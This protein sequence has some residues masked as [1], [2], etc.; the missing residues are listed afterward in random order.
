MIP[1]PNSNLATQRLGDQPAITN[2]IEQEQLPDD[3]LYQFV[4]ALGTT[5]QPT[6]YEMEIWK[7]A[8]RSWMRRF[9]ANTVYTHASQG[10]VWCMG[11][12]IVNEANYGS[13]FGPIRARVGNRA[14]AYSDPGNVRQAE[15]EVSTRDAE[16]TILDDL[17]EFI[18]DQDLNQVQSL[19]IFIIG[20]QGPC[21]ICQLRIR[22]F[23]SDLNNIAY[24][25]H[26]HIPLVFEAVYTT[27]YQ[28]QV[29]RQG[30][31]TQYGYAN[32]RAITVRPTAGGAPYSIWS[33]SFTLILGA[34]Q[35]INI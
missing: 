10:G 27:V 18:T 28:P 29:N 8:V 3:D 32:A 22:K 26:H 16:I 33:K 12:I 30:I 21:S 17:S 14:G 31:Q 4:T 23:I 15:L 1:V 9:D 35:V 34:S 2:L 6:P 13:A 7:K 19:H 25:G 20:S 11:R 24:Y 5:P